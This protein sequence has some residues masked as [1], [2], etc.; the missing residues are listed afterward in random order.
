MA[1]FE[2][3]LICLINLKEDC[4]GSVGMYPIKQF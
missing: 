4:S 3:K 1:V 2:L